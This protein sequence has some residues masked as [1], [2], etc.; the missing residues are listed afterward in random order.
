MQLEESALIERGQANRAKKLCSNFLLES[1]R[2]VI[3]PAPLNL[4]RYS[5]PLPGQVMIELENE[6]EIIAELR[7]LRQIE[8]RNYENQRNFY[9]VLTTGVGIATV[10]LICFFTIYFFNKQ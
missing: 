6:R 2:T 10:I 9:L 1:Q 8:T 3:E 7:L 5:F 4:R